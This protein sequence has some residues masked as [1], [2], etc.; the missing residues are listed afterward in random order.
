MGKQGE[1]LGEGWGVSETVPLRGGGGA[2]LKMMTLVRRK[3][4]SRGGTG[5]TGRGVTGFAP[6]IGGFGQPT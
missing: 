4:A 2:L 5:G 6:N 1:V 3:N